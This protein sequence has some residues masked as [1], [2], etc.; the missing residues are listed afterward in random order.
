MND[1][2]TNA[3]HSPAPARGDEAIASGERPSGPGRPPKPDPQALRRRKLFLL[4]CLAV[5][6]FLTVI[7]VMNIL[8]KA[9]E[10]DEIWTVQHYRNIPVRAVFSDVSTPNNHVLNTLGVR[11]F[12][13]AIPYNNRNLA[14]RMTALLAYCG[15]FLVLLRASL[16]LLKNDAARGGVLIVV[17]LNGMMLHY[18]E[19]ARGYSLQSL[20]LFGLFFSLLCFQFRPPENRLFNAVMWLLCAVGACLSVSSGVLYVALLTGLWG[21]LY[22]P[23]REG[24]KGIWQEYRSLILAGLL[25]SGFVLAWYGFNYSKF[26]AGRAAFGESFRSPAQYC[27]YCF[28]AARDTGLIWVLPCLAVCGVLLRGKRQWRLCALTGGA[29]VLAFASALLTKGG[30]AR[31]YLPLLAPA[32]FAIGAAADVWLTDSRKLRRAA[33]WIL[34]VLAA[35]CIFFSDRMRRRVAD[36]NM[37]VIFQEVAKLDPHMFVS[38]KS[39]DLYVVRMLFHDAAKADDFNRQSEPWMLLLLHENTVSAV[40]AGEFPIEELVSPGVAPVAVEYLALEESVF[41]WLYRLRPVQPG[42][43]LDGRAVLCFTNDSIRETTKQWLFDNFGVVNSMLFEP[44][45][46]RICFA[47][48]G[49]GLNADVLRK[50]EQSNQG[51]LFFRVVSD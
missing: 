37:A 48:S 33:P 4:V 42:E 6:A 46:T 20:F 50:L 25:F 14:M 22:V 35:V 43:T 51:S 17:L 28:K 49:T 12:L 45:S 47:A 1:I 21:I 2:Q 34:F 44:D 32:V 19:T 15:L 5:F 23:F 13:S 30:P 27:S 16:L 29:I 18:A 26:A 40:H 8:E 31:I 11:F 39:T 41:S 10:Y 9:P 38:Y 7:R 36:P 24:A 3:E